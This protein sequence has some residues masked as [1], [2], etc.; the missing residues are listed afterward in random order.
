MALNCAP[1]L[2]NLNLKHRLLNHSSIAKRSSAKVTAAFRGGNAPQSRSILANAD[3][4]RMNF[5]RPVAKPNLMKVMQ[6][7][8]V[9]LS[10][11]VFFIELS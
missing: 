7:G 9:S 10:S 4:G 5:K 3:G 6:N 2:L 11:F 1:P 8:T